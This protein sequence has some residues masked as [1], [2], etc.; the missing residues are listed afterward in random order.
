MRKKIKRGP[1]T[2]AQTW[3]YCLAM[4]KW[5]SENYIAGL[6]TVE[7]LKKRWLYENKIRMGWRG[8]SCFFCDYSN[9]QKNKACSKSCPGAKVSPNFDCLNPAYYFTSKPR[10]FYQ[11]LLRM[12]RKRKKELRKN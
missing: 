5:V 3:E 12:D 11:K 2:L 9:H 1:F 4:W 6:N 7:E 10:K 8:L